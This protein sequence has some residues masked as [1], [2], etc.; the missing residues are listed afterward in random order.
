MGAYFD[1]V[2]VPG[3]STLAL[4]SRAVPAIVGAAACA[5]IVLALAVKSREGSIT[6]SVDDGGGWLARSPAW[7]V[8][9][10]LY[11]TEHPPDH[12]AFA[13]AGGRVR[14]VIPRLERTIRYRLDVHARSGRAPTDPPA[15]VRVVVDGLDAGAY[16]VAPERQDLA[17]PLPT[18]RRH[19]AVI[20]LETDQTFVPGPQD[21]RAL[22][23][24]I[25][26]FTLTP[27][28][29]ASVP[30]PRASVLDVGLFAGA[31]AFAVVLC[32]L[33]SWLAFT[34]GTAVGAA[35]ARLV[36]FDAAFLGDYS[37]VLAVLAC[38]LVA[39]VG[40]SSLV[41][42]QASMATRRGWRV[43]VLLSLVVT[44]LRLAVF[45]HPDAPVSDGMFH[46]HRAQA[47][48][49]GQYFFT[50][51]TPR[52]FYEFPYPV[53][54]YVAAEPLW[55]RFTNHVALLRGIT[56]AADALVA[57]GLFAVVSARS[58]SASTGVLATALAL[59]IPVVPQS[60]STANLTNVFA[61][62][63]FSLG[64]LWVGWHLPSTR[65][66]LAVAGT[67]ALVAAAYLSHFS[68]AVIGA[69]A[70]ALVALL[71]ACARDPREARAW[72]WVAL[73]VALALGLSYAAYY[74]HF[75]DVYV[76]TLSR[77]GSE[78]AE[79][80]LV[81]TLAEH[82]ESKPVTML[83]FLVSNYGWA[84][85]LLATVG[86]VAALRRDWRQGWTLVL[87]ALGVTVVGFLLL[88]AFTP[89][90]MRANLAAHPVLA[91]FGALG[92]AELWRTRRFAF[93]AVAV[94]AMIWITWVGI[95]TLGAVLG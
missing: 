22:G 23:Y 50:S 55:D 43:A 32:G 19:G 14:L 61:Q 3:R 46:V 88:G 26:R 2:S 89:V 57:I 79:T 47:V 4:I 95:G 76:R 9:R 66:A 52:P 67:V 40:L 35:G 16:A 60:V 71:V 15:V 1:A 45:L 87:L 37:S 73:S 63:C 13:W 44:V 92:V 27:I 30:V 94:A 28:D 34:V 20:L 93:R 18:A 56:L 68:T 12:V 62:S 25:E 84:T 80:S 42:G 8:T 29:A 54:L 49:G 11:P 81:A 59:A 58:G 6:R 33:P 17:V 75:H 78:G 82:S 69:P 24:I 7:F 10:G 77:V 21:T 85:L 41:A 74:S 38:A 53:G 70:A 83:R 36:L 39:S 86:L 5:A 51:V 31:V 91:A 65:R 72:R 90:E 48:Y 64:I